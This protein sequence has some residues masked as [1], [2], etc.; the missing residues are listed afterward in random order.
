MPRDRLT[1]HNPPDLAPPTGYSHVAEVRGGTLVFVAG[2]VALDGTGAL[3]GPGDYRAQ[4]EQVFRNLERALASAG[5]TFRDV[6]KLNY[7]VLDLSH[8]PEIR[9]VR[10]RFVDTK[11]PPTS[12]A[13]QVSRLF[14]PEFLLEV[15]LVASVPDR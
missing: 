15:D 5:A 12:T 13:V 1:L 10:D 6:V 11:H 2:Q 9:E 7:F 14:R 4:A 3:V 8:L